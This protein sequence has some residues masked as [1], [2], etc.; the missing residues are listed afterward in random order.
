[1][2][3]PIWLVVHFCWKYVI[4]DHNR[5]VSCFLWHGPCQRCRWG[6]RNLLW[7][8]LCRTRGGHP[9]LH[10]LETTRNLS[11][12]KFHSA[13]VEITHECSK[14]KFWYN[15]S[16]FG[17]SA[18]TGDL[19]TLRMTIYRRPLCETFTSCTSHER[20]LTCLRTSRDRDLEANDAKKFGY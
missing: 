20:P 17:V 7:D 2:E 3:D 1:M 9:F 5:A 10:N 6:T 15:L 4:A 18:V 12:K 19:S 16:S 14:S 11:K 8:R 13:A